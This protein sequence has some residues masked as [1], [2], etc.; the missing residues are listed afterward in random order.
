MTSTP[1][2]WGLIQPRDLRRMGEIISVRAE[3]ERWC[4][5][6]ML[7]GALPFMWRHKAGVVRDFMYDQLRLRTGDKVLIVGEVVEGS[8]F[9]EDIRRRIGPEGE[10]RIIDITD[11]ARDAYFEERRGRGGQLA[12]WRYDYTSTIDDEHF[13]CV[14]V[15][16]AVQHTD[17]WRET[18][19]EL[20]RIMKRGRV[21][22]LAE[23][24]FKNIN[25]FAALDLHLEYWL[26]KMFA[27]IG[28][29]RFEFPYYS[30]DDLQQAFS[31]MVTEAKVFAW[32]GLE[33]F[34][35]TKA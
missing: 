12:T 2:P 29:P 26:E 34:W 8:G 32:R 15:L 24:T 21:I 14:A 16:Q 22:L 4:R 25:E 23:I 28:I 27:R 3:Q 30:P 1:D 5:A 9:D 31:G 11:E 7:A 35:A 33:L 17:D 6:V 10:I 19:K 13:D 18:G 20:L